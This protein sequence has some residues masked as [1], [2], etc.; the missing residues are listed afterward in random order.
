M[1][2]LKLLGAAVVGVVASSG[3]ALAAFTIDPL[4]TVNLA[5]V[6]AWLGIAVIAM[7]ALMGYRKFIKTGNR[8]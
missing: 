2:K 1:K 6:E 4:S 7:L 8:T 3:S 5:P